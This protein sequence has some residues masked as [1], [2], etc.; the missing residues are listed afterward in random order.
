MRKPRW[1]KVSR[2]TVPVFLLAKEGAGTNTFDQ[3]LK[4]FIY[5]INVGCGD[6]EEVGD[7]RE[8]G[9]VAKGL[10]RAFDK[11]SQPGIEEGVLHCELVFVMLLGGV[12]EEKCK[13]VIGAGGALDIFD[14][15]VLI[16]DGNNV[17][18]KGEG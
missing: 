4:V 8:V 3:K 14:W 7:R 9:D 5:G 13:A 10:D 11:V 18:S 12:G 17:N 16:E 6:G 15:F 2:V 1:R